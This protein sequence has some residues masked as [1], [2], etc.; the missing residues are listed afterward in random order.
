MA[1]SK[2]G[3]PVFPTRTG[4]PLS[5]LPSRTA[6][7]EKRTKTR[8]SSDDQRF[9]EKAPPS[10]INRWVTAS[11]STEIPIETG[12]WLNWVTQLVVIPFH[13][14]PEAAPT[15]TRALGILKVTRLMSSMSIASFVIGCPL[16]PNVVPVRILVA[17]AAVLP[18]APVAEF[19]RVLIGEAA[20]VT[21]MT[22]VQVPRSF[23]E[24][25]D[26]TVRR[27]FLDEDESDRAAEEK[28]ARYLE[29]RGR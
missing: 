14:S 13:S 8:V 18:A 10:V 26:G 2:M 5:V 6:G 24:S 22:V 25:L 16:D 29:E 1:S 4:R 3:T 19:C 27:S 11:L 17:T 28:A 23:L 12:S 15:S 20:E 21:V 9:T 7:L